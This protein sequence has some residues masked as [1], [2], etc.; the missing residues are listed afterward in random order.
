[1]NSAVVISVLAATGTADLNGSTCVVS[2]TS[3]V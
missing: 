1:L 2:S 3:P